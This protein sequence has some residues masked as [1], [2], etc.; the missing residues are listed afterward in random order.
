M[1]DW[2]QKL[3]H[4]SVNTYLLPVNKQIKAWR[5]ADRKMKWGLG[6]A[7]F[8]AIGS[9]PGLSSGDLADGFT[10]V[11]LSHGFGYDGEGHADAV[12]SGRLAWVY[13]RKRSRSR[14]WH[15]QYIDFKKADHFRYRP[16][17]ETYDRQQIELCPD[18]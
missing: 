15:C 5:K 1:I 2:I 13:V 7:A 18:A 16:G 4:K 17:E 3:L 9:P 11:I 12:L 10:G 8:A 14:T 6:E